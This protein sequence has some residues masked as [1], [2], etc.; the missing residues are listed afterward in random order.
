M[1][2]KLRRGVAVHRT[3]AVVLELGGGPFA[4]GLRRSVAADPRLRVFLDL[5]DGDTYALAVRLPHSLVTAHQRGKRDTLRRAERRIPSGPV[6]HR[7]HRLA[8]IV[9]ILARLL[10]SDELLA[11][12][13]MLPL[14]EMRKLL[15]AHFSREA[16]FLGELALPLA[17]DL[18]R[19]V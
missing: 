6:L 2:V 3:A 7:L 16:P 11:G 12:L 15:G 13:G 9:R 4:G 8:G 14:C 5:I 17:P 10:V 1:R 18:V 19:C